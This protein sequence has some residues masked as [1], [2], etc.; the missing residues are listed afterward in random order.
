MPKKKKTRS[1]ITISTGHKDQ[2]IKMGAHIKHLREQ[3]TGESYEVFA[4]NNGINRISQ[5]RMEK[6]ENFM[7]VNLLKI[8]DGLEI[9]MKDFFKDINY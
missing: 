7:M 4:K 2:L 3:V 8:L 1:D 5:Y 9:T 6:G